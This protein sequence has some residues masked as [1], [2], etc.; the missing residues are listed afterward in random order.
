MLAKHKRLL[1]LLLGHLFSCDGGTGLCNPP[2]SLHLSF[3]ILGHLRGTVERS[4]R[5][6]RTLAR[7]PEDSLA[8][9]LLAELACAVE[10]MSS[11]K[12]QVWFKIHNS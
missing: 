2:I 11:S 3:W 5:D 9:K 1:I 7:P 8:A 4:T 6:L 12:I 10:Q